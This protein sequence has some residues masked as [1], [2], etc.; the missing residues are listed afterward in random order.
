MLPVIQ[1][2]SLIPLSDKNGLTSGWKVGNN[3][4]GTIDIY[5]GGADGSMRS[6]RHTGRTS[7]GGGPS[8]VLD[9]GCLVLG[10]QYQFTAKYK[11]LDENNNNEPYLCTNGV[12]WGDPLTCPLFSIK[13]I[14]SDGNPVNAQNFYNEDHTTIFADEFNQ[15]TTT[16][17]VTDQ[18]ATAIE[19]EILLK[20]PVAGIAIL[21]DDVNINLYEPPEYDCA[22][23]V[24]DGDFEVSKLSTGKACL[25]DGVNM[26]K[27]SNIFC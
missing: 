6:Y 3:G 22:E 23:M 26:L 15:Y 19:A 9:L 10:R 20:G 24:P 12:S 7:N 1:L 14:D 13:M 27:A 16:F 17:T 21:F 4:G 18:M 8:H 5:S 25:T 11:L 2:T